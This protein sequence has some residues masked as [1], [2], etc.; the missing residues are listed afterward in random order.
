M[1]AVVVNCVVSGS[2]LGLQWYPSFNHLSVSA[3]P[4]L[5]QV[6]VMTGMRTTPRSD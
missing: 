2:L 1:A 6:A 5:K 4:H 3:Y